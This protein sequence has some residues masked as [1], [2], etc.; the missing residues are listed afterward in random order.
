[1][2]VQDVVFL[3]SRASFSTTF[4]KSCSTCE[5]LGTSTLLKTVARGRQGHTPSGIFLLQ[6]SLYSVSVKCHEDHMTVIKLR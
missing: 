4:L 3:P 1:M 5:G 2:D 6:Q